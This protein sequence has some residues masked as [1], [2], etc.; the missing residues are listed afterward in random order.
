[1]TLNVD[2]DVVSV[3]NAFIGGQAWVVYVY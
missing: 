2:V 3:V 1:V